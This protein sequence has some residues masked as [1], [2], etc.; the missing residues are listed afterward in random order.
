MLENFN[1]FDFDGIETV[2]WIKSSWQIESYTKG[3]ILI[4]ACQSISDLYILKTG[5]LLFITDFI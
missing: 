3:S 5:K 1:I 2:S 4:E